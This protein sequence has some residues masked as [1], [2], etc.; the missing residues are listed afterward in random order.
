LPI[1]LDYVIDD[2]LLCQDADHVHATF[3]IGPRTTRLVV[4]VDMAACW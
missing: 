1:C 3:R 2:I 4:E